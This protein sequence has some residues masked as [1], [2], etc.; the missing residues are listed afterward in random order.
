[1]GNV[2]IKHQ[3]Q[4]RPFFDNHPASSRKVFNH[5]EV[6]KSSRSGSLIVPPTPH[7]PSSL[8]P[9]K[10]RD[11]Y[12]PIMPYRYVHKSAIKQN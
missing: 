2:S 12:S 7:L 10:V 11:S 9:R 4:R 1:M 8:T 5:R 6:I 3:L